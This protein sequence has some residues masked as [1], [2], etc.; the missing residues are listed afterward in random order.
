MTRK[1][2]PAPP[3]VRALGDRG[4]GRKRLFEGVDLVHVGVRMT[5]DQKAKLQALGGGAWIRDRI[6][7]AKDPE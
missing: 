3:A 7:R 4:Q 1:K 6:D 5:P 2:A